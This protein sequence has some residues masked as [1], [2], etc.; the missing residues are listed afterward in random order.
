MGGIAPLRRLPKPGHWDAN[1]ALP[2]WPTWSKLRVQHAGCRAPS[3]VIAFLLS[4]DSTFTKAECVHVAACLHWSPPS[5]PSTVC[6]PLHTHTP[7]HRLPYQNQ[8]IARVVAA[9]AGSRRVPRAS[10]GLTAA[11]MA[12]RVQYELQ[13]GKAA[14]FK[15]RCEPVQNI[16]AFLELLNASVNRK[17]WL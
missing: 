6:L 2:I 16:L 7:A 15:V 3:C 12:G 11:A 9:N 8:H 10:N 17:C 14:T 1:W 13:Y 4:P 5:L